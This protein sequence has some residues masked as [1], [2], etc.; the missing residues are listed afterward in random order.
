M[1]HKKF[2]ERPRS[3]TISL[4]RL[5]SDRLDE[6][7]IN[8]KNFRIVS[9]YIRWTVKTGKIEEFERDYLKARESIS[10]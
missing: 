7:K 3:T 1:A 8:L 2:D 6:M 4:D 9:D 10:N 5:T